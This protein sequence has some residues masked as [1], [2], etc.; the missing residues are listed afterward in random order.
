M[1]YVQ[2]YEKEDG[3]KVR[4]HYREE[5]KDLP[6]SM[7]DLKNSE[8]VNFRGE[9]IIIADSPKEDKQKVG[10]FPDGE[11]VHFGDP[12]MKEYPGTDRGDNYCARSYGMAKKYNTTDEARNANSLSRWYLWN[13]KK[14]KSMKSRKK[15]K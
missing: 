9:K 14:D 1:V 7:K 11:E 13:C 5:P 10:V 4:G 6:Y 15:A 8:K 2:P 3:T 12:D